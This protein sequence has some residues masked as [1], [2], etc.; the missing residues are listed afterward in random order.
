M[1]NPFAD[2][3]SFF[4]S[5]NMLVKLIIINIAVWI[6]IMLLDRIFFLFN[7]EFTVFVEQW[8]AVPA[9]L[10]KLITRPWTL[11]TY[12]FLHIGF[13]HILVNMLWLY[14][15]GRIF[16]E[17]L[18]ERQ[19]LSTYIM[20]GLVGALFFILSFNIFPKFQ[21]VYIMAI[22]L[23]A[24]ASVKAIV[25]AISYY[26]PNYSINLFFLGPVRIIYIALVT[27]FID[28]FMIRSDNSGGYIAHIGGVLWGFYYIYMLKKGT[29]F[30]KLFAAFSWKNLTQ[31]F[32]R[33]KKTKF[34]NVYTNPR[35]TT[36]EDYNLQKKKD[37]EKVD[38]I[39]DKISKSGYESLTKQEKELLF[40][41]SNKN[42]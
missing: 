15:F 23:G 41:T 10:G 34:K 6:V 4:K 33:P 16:L 9:S 18:N 7:A 3:K 28:L 26:V 11:L 30:S 22:A 14:W 36:D 39:L 2:L 40:R 24:S 8:F 29:D 19:L 37:Q 20:G 12:M 5:K 32:M 21:D 13:W 25:V 31:P 27:I 1:Q 17:Y 35:T 42:K 38:T